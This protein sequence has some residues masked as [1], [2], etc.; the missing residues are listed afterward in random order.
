MN[1]QSDAGNIYEDEQVLTTLV[2]RKQ[3]FVDQAICA[4]GLND[5]DS[6]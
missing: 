6:E 3:T 2:I 1:A 4:E 5:N